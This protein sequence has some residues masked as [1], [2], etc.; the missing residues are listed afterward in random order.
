VIAFDE[1]GKH[2]DRATFWPVMAGRRSFLDHFGQEHDIELDPSVDDI[3]A[4]FIEG[5]DDA[6]NEEGWRFGPHRKSFD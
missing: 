3:Y 5:A 2:K 1:R 4:I 6:T